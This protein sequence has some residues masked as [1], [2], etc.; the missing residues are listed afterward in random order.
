MPGWLAGALAL[1]ACAPAPGLSSLDEV[2]EILAAIDVDPAPGTVEVELRLEP[3]DLEILEG[4]TTPGLTYRD[5]SAAER[6]LLPGP[7]IEVEVGQT[8]SVWLTNGLP[9]QETTLHFHGMRTPADLDGNPLIRS[10]ID[11]GRTMLHRFVVQDPGLYWFHPHLFSDE[12][13]ELGLQGL[14]VARAPDEPR[15]ARERIFV[16]DDVDLLPDGSMAIEPS[17]QDHHLGRHGPTVIVNGRAPGRVR[18]IAG[19]TERWRFVNTANGRHFAL[20]LGGRT[21]Q[22]NAVDGTPRREPVSPALP[23]RARFLPP[24]HRPPLSA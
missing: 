16:L 24:H 18:A 22:V 20:P 8:L 6:H 11:P 14:V 10:G 19:A 5:L 23:Q 21:F 4:A 2:P 17:H 3:S 12:H 15:A 13:V 7:V 9:D 1:C